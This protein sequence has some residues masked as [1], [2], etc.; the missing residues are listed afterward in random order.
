MRGAHEPNERNLHRYTVLYC[1]EN[2]TTTITI[3]TTTDSSTCNTHNHISL[4]SSPH[5]KHP[6]DNN[7]HPIS[8][9]RPKKANKE[10]EFLR[11]NTLKKHNK[12]TT[13]KA[14]IVNH[15]PCL[16]HVPYSQPTHPLPTT[17]QIL[18]SPLLKSAILYASCLTLPLASRPC[19]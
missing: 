1:W 13:K 19:S 16:H 12:K 7:T 9:K 6:L 10:R 11:H 15:P 3:T 4:P 8:Q 2:K 5:R 14:A 17:L 18:T